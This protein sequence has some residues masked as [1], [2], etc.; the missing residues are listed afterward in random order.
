[1]HG[2]RQVRALRS[3]VS[4]WGRLS[5]GGEEWE[6]CL[7]AKNVCENNDNHTMTISINLSSWPAPLQQQCGKT[8]EGRLMRGGPR[9]QRFNSELAPGPW[10]GAA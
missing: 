6:F 2:V 10:L 1:M 9:R 3:F 4:P 8:G 7:N 5:G